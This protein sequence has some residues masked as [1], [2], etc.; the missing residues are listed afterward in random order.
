LEYDTIPATVK[1]DQHV[2]LSSFLF[3][4]RPLLLFAAPPFWF[5]SLDFFPTIVVTSR[6]DGFLFTTSRL[7]L[8]D[9]VNQHGGL[10]LKLPYDV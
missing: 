7:P 4:L 8:F 6:G 1:S 10:D 9:T 2:S 5:F 3:F